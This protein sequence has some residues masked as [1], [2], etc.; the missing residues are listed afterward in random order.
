MDED[1]LRTRLR[2]L[3]DVD[4]P[5]T[6]D[7]A[8]VL[9]AGR[10]RR[11]ARSVGAGA[12][13]LTLVVG[14]YPAVTALLPDRAAVLP[15]GPSPTTGSPAPRAVVD[16]EAGTITLPG[17]GPTTDPADASVLATARAHFLSVCMAE[18]GYAEEWA[19]DGPVVPEVQPSRRVP[20][21]VWRESDV[22]ATG[23]GHVVHSP[24]R[25]LIEP[26][27]GSVVECEAALVAAG[28]A[29]D[30]EDLRALAA[31]DGAGLREW[32]PALLTGEGR[33][34][35]EQWSR[36][37]A[38]SGVVAGDDPESMIPEGVLDAPFDEQV[39]VGLLDVACKERLDLVQ[40]MADLDAAA[41]GPVQEQ[42]LEAAASFRRLEEPVVARARAYLAGQG[43]VVPS[44]P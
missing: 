21:G 11:V 42:D 10:R 3:A 5:V 27:L 30:E 14:A 29:V 4:P 25:E 12:A 2:R 32:Q 7:R 22:R 19:F 26:E 16:R 28:L 41:R 9:R 31:Q 1:L 24:G 18:R 8:G 33:A 35:R 34:L 36:C 39:R 44:V 13:V 37:L 23:Y 15:A 6:V 38:E 20:Y 40:R 17:D 43:I